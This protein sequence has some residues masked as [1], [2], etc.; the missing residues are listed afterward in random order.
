MHHQ[1][2]NN[3]QIF[4]NVLKAF[5]GT[6]YLSLPF[7]FYQSGIVT[8]AVSFIIKCKNAAV[9]MILHSSPKYQELQTEACYE[10]MAKIKET[11]EKEMTLG[12]IGKIAVGPWGSR[13]VNTALIITQTGFCIAYFIFMGNTI[14]EMFPIT[15]KAHSVTP[16]KHSTFFSGVTTGTPPHTIT[17]APMNSSTMIPPLEGKT[18]APMFVLLVLIPLP[19]LVVMAYVAEYSTTWTSQWHC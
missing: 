12:D 2:G 18:T 17:A 10:E 14:A 3:S 9:D 7:A 13:L 16:S 8:T 19:F 11:I 5:I 4:A 15:Y 6:S 1:I